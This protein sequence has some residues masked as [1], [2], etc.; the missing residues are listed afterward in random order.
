MQFLC[1]IAPSLT[2]MA[3][4]SGLAPTSA[5]SQPGRYQQISNPPATFCPP[6]GQNTLPPPGFGI[7][8]LDTQTGTVFIHEATEWR[9]EN[10]QNGKTAIHDLN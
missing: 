1:P 9:E 2:L 8:I 3:C 6:L 5:P 4:T 10:P 7:T